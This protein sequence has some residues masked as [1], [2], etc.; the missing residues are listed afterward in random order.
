MY[1]KDIKELIRDIENFP[2][3]GVTFKDITPLLANAEAFAKIIDEMEVIAK[4]MNVDVIVGPESRGFIFGCPLAYKMGVGFVPARKPLKLPSDHITESYETEYGPA[5]LSIHTDAITKGQRVL[6]I[7]DL[8][9]TGGTIEA[10]SKLIKKLGG[11]VAGAIFLIELE[12]LGGAKKLSDSN[13][14]YKAL[15]KYD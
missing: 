7:D 1:M 10:S 12:A 8:L 13:I 3:E 5:A 11:E 9:A 15:V 2:N 6:I 14:N 4:E